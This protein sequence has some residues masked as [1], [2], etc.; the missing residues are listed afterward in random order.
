MEFMD[1]GGHHQTRSR[2]KNAMCKRWDTPT[3]P[4]LLLITDMQITN[5]EDV[6]G[7]LAGVEGRVTVIHIGEN[8]ATD[9][10]RQATQ[11]HPR[12]QIFSVAE[13]QDIPHIVLGQVRGYLAFS[14]H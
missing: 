9:R 3:V 14:G 5:L 1:R 11:N 7:F 13:R 4:D 2:V 8:R 6:I 10:F 12:L